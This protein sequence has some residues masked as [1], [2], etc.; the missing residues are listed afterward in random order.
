MEKKDKKKK[1][2]D[3]PDSTSGPVNIVVP[4][5]SSTLPKN[6]QRGQQRGDS[7]SRPDVRLFN[8]YKIYNDSKQTVVR[9]KS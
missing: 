9:S 2:D 3:V 4:K 5:K 1:P 8:Y 6:I 7:S